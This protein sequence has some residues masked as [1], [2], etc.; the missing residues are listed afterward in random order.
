MLKQVIKS[1]LTLAAPLAL[2]APA[3]SQAQVDTSDW[4]CESCPFDQGYR[5]EFDAGATNVSDDAA[6]FGNYTGYDEEGTHADV[7]GHGRYANE[8][9]RMDWY[10]EDLGLDARVLELS[11]GK[12][13]VFDFRLGY[14]DIPFR[15]FDTSST[16][17]LPT[18]GDSLTL[19]GGW[20][21]ASTTGQ[22][23]QLS[24]SLQQRMVGTDRSIVDLGADWTPGDAFRLFADFRR[25]TRDG[26]DISSAGSY[27]QAAFLPLA[28]Q[29]CVWHANPIMTFPRCRCPA[30]TAWQLVTRSLRFSRHPDAANR[31][32]T[33]CPTRSTPR[34]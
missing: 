23:T 4:A 28:Q 16:V 10:A 7:S 34:S 22:M 8:G 19:P 17:F 5:A 30:S 6:R 24:S 15:R 12:Q 1:C 9:Y 2:L 11:A 33:S 31:M 18:S 27:T 21:P 25:Q 32:R 13:G 26:V 3:V 20:V 14:R 29:A